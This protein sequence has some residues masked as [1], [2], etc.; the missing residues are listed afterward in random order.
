MVSLRHGAS[1]KGF[2]LVLFLMLPCHG[3]QV[4]ATEADSFAR[5][6]RWIKAKIGREDP[7][8]PFDNSNSSLG[9]GLP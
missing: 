4:K 1:M 9:D 3:M 6:E 5:K 2:Q 8:P 7:V